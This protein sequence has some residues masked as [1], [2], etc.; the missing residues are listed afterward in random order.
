MNRARLSFHS[1]L[2]KNIWNIS[3]DEL[4]YRTRIPH[5]TSA[6]IG[7]IP[8]AQTQRDCTVKRFEITKLTNNN[9]KQ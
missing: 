2:P 9:A 3:S 6:N 5:L 8:D 1:Q 4:I 7:K